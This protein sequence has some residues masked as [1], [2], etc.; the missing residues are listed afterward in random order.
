MFF[1]PVHYEPVRLEFHAAKLYVGQDIK[2]TDKTYNDLKQTYQIAIL[3]K[4]RFFP[5]NNYFHSFEYFDPINQVSLNS[6]TR[7]ITLELVK[8]SEKEEKPVNEMS[9]SECWTYYFE[10]LTNRNSRD[11]II[12]ILE[13][14]E[15]IAMA[16][17]VLNTIS[18]D[19]EERYRIMRDE[20]I[21]LDYCKIGIR[22]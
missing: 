18:R 9:V 3:A 19:E 1:N 5:D 8:A 2:G 13:K 21:L 14:E 11:K 6:R 20:K 22:N 12:E 15:G 10:Y 7:I 4:E 16:N 17:Q